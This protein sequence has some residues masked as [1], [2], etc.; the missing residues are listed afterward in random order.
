LVII[1]NGAIQQVVNRSRDWSRVII[2]IPLPLDEDLDRAI[3]ILGELAAQMAGEDEW[4]KLL[5]DDPVVAGVESLDTS[6]LKVRVTAR[7]LPTKQVAV[8]RE[9]RR[10][11]ALALREA[12]I[13]STA[14]A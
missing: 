5:L 12:G 6:S 4:H 3:D 1:P 11:I 9:L 8:G 13:T 14:A 7:T 2:D 10:R